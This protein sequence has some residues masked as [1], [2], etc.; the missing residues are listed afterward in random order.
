MAFFKTTRDQLKGNALVSHLEFANQFF[1]PKNMIR[2]EL[3]IRGAQKAL[4][5]FRAAE[6]EYIFSDDGWQYLSTL[7]EPLQIALRMGGFTQLASDMA[8]VVDYVNRV[9]AQRGI[10][11]DPPPFPPAAPDGSSFDRAIV[12]DG[13]MLGFAAIVEHEYLREHYP[14]YK[15]QKQAIRQH[16]GRS[17]DVVEFTTVDGGTKKLYFAL[18]Q[19]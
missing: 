9:L 14:S 4:I 3:H 10:P 12:I 15:V 13:A 2:C 17:F 8:H 11:V 7:T 16:A 1:K 19:L 5:A 6:A 18:S